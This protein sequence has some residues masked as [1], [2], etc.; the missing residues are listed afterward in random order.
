MDFFYWGVGFVVGFAVYCFTAPKEGENRHLSLIIPVPLTTKALH[1]HDW[2]Y[3]LLVYPLTVVWQVPALQGF[4][5]GGVVQSFVWYTDS[6]EVVVDRNP[7]PLLPLFTTL[8]NNI[9]NGGIE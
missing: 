2:L 9:E 7:T 4:C 3:L 6:F 1:I 8:Q 5:L